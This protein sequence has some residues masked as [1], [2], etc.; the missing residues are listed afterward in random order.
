MK[1][2]KLIITLQLAI[3]LLICTSCW[4]G[5]EI[6][7]RAV[8]FSLGIDKN[9][10]TGDVDDMDYPKRYRVSYA[11]PDMSKVSGDDSISEDVVAIQTA[12]STTFG[13]TV[14][15]VQ[16]KTQDT[17]NFGHT[18]AILLG[19]DLLRDPVMMKEIIDSLERNM[20]FTRSTP[21]FAV[22][23]TA[24]EVIDVKNE[25]HPMVGL[26]IMN[27]V[28]NT[29][30]AVSR[31]KEALLGNT[32]RDLRE[33]N[34]AIIPI[35]DIVD[36]SKIEIKG[37]ALLKDF[38]LQA[39]FSP[40]EVRG[41]LWTEGKVR[42]AIIPVAVGESY[43]S[44]TVRKQ[45]SKIR[46]HNTDG[47]LSCHIDIMNEGEIGEYYIN[48]Q[49]SLTNLNSIE[50][51]ESQI[52]SIIRQEIIHLIAETKQYNTD[53]IGLGAELHRQH[54]NWWDHVASD[55]D[56]SYKDME[57]KVTVDTKIRRTGIIE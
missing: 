30:R 19:A 15:Q 33:N 5:I 41:I 36:G 27:Y 17:I 50:K 34:A 31:Y 42:G 7:R 49:D 24:H 56:E 8:I 13:A 10:N 51:I 1:K 48:S 23:N 37:G 11:I 55:W 22:R 53:I 47:T 29:E 43:L 28:N 14:E 52:S 18:K 6:N 2:S 26:Y 39:W 16:T 45:D 40:E 32:I 21:L 38:K 44:Y 3:C 9:E 46:F 57:I 12:E 35:I 20:L 4:D 54:P 25:Q